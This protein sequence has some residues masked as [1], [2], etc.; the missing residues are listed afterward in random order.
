MDDELPQISRLIKER[1]YA[2]ARAQLL[3]YLEENPDDA[4]AWYLL[5][6][7]GATQQER[8]DAIRRAQELAPNEK[9]VQARLKALQAGAEQRKRLTLVYGA[10]AVGFAGLLIVG[11]ALLRSR[12]ITVS[13]GA[14]SPVGSTAIADQPQ[15]SIG[16]TETPTTGQGMLPSTPAPD[17][18]AALTETLGSSA[19][20]EGTLTPTITLSP[21]SPLPDG[22]TPS[23]TSTDTAPAPAPVN[24]T[25]S[26]P[27]TTPSPTVPP[28]TP[29]PPNTLVPTVIPTIVAGAVP[30]G[31]A[32]TLDDGSLRVVSFT[33]P[34]QGRITEMG[35]SV[36][37]P[38]AGSSWAL[39]ELLMVCTGAE[40]CAISPSAFQIVGTTGGTYS[41]TPIP[42][43]DP[44]LFGPNAYTY[45]Q[46]WGY[47]GFVI[48]NTESSL[49]LVLTLDDGLHVFALQ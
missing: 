24:P 22:A 32:V 7:A 40:N 26:Q 36:A 19:P 8:N 35:G 28:P 23:P 42:G 20:P 47:I 33:R 17:Q 41:S 6:F 11:F 44:L 5:S 16:I 15:A 27:T 14:S 4:R 12:P 25:E 49:W 31:E 13:E 34:A 46:V 29:T 38:P 1:R 18:T 10:L 30:L 39:V 45:G 48:P 9:K 21:S 2:E 43:L 3:A 37:A